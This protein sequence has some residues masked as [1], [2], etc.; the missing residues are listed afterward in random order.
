MARL[1]A[2]T[3]QAETSIASRRWWALVACC[4]AACARALTPPI[5]VYREPAV[6][7]FNEGWVYYNLLMSVVT[8]GTLAFLLIGGVLGDMFGRRRLLLTGLSGLCVA[9]LLT[10]LSPEPA[11][12]L[13]MRLLG[14][15]SSA[16]VVPL[17]LSVLYLAFRDD[18]DARTL[19]VAAYIA[20]TTTAGLSA[21]LLGQ[22]ANSLL[23]WRATV[24]V[25]TL[26]A[27]AG[28]L[29]VRKTVTESRV[30]FSRGVDMVG[31]ALW[32]LGTLGA[33]VGITLSRVAG[34]Y[35]WAVLGASIAA[36]LL[37][38]AVLLWW[39]KHVSSSLLQRNKFPR[40]ALL[41]LIVFGVSLQIDFGAFVGLLRN[42]LID[43]YGYSSLRA[44][45]SL[46]PLLLGM[47]LT[48]LYGVPRLVH[49]RARTVMSGCLLAMSGV[50]ALT[51]LTRAAEWYPWLAVL[52]F[53]F[54]AANVGANTAWTAIF[55][56]LV[57]KDALG[58]RTGIN[59][60]VS[61]VGGVI[62]AAL[63]ASLLASF[64][65]VDYLGRLLAAGVDRIQIDAALAALNTIL[66]TSS[67]DVPIDPAIRDR[68]LSGYQTAYLMALDRVLL[69][70]AGIGLLGCAVLWFGLPHKER[71]APSVRHE[72]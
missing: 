43:V 49:L 63:S 6:L 20:V 1:T 24:L 64:G 9:N 55:F 48:V 67:F 4:A 13:T 51:A 39:D 21:G 45:V 37:A 34:A 65:M 10:M 59:S 5:W 3:A 7:A 33:L 61:Q 69:I 14:G 36:V 12:L 70:V 35:T 72:D 29:L 28:L 22:L 50:I 66:S 54:G 19:A 58:V 44:G 56:T 27:V 25:P 26:L 16:L 8:V 11:W 47:L 18:A 60:S 40:R 31:N 68:L 15:A 2:E 62:G 32:S 71:S 42:L 17:S 41:V 57:P 53:V 23:S 46:A 38:A 52:L 30:A